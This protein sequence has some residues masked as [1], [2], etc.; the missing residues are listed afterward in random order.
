MYKALT[1]ALTKPMS[2][3]KTQVTLLPDSE[4]N[5]LVKPQ[6]Q[7]VSVPITPVPQPKSAYQ[8]QQPVF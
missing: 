4:L 1:D 8:P 2:A 7:A 5:V 6:P 3:Q